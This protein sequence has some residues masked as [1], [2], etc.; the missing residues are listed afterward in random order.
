M[1]RADRKDDIS[2]LLGP[3][4]RNRGHDEPLMP[5]R[6][7]VR[8]PFGASHPGA[9]RW[10]RLVLC[11]GVCCRVGWC[12]ASGGAVALGGVACRGALQCWGFGRASG[13]TGSGCAPALGPGLALGALWPG[14]AIWSGPGVLF[15]GFMML[16]LSALVMIPVMA[17]CWCGHRVPWC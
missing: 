14:A 8:H 15:R 3:V 1:R 5:G 11:V 4:W 6:G 7:D 10:P 9:L 2:S 12:P 16:L 13:R 17:T